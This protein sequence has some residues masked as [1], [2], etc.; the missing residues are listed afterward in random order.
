MIFYIEIAVVSFLHVLFIVLASAWYERPNG[1]QS[2]APGA[3][4]SA[5][6]LGSLVC[7]GVVVSLHSVRKCVLLCPLC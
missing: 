4:R 3:F 1:D 2:S 5:P 6:V 7:C